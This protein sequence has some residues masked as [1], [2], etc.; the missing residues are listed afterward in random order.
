MR[1]TLRPAVIAVLAF[2]LLGFVPLFTSVEKVNAQTPYYDLFRDATAASRSNGDDA[3][4]AFKVI[5]VGS[6]ESGL[7]AVASGGDITFTE[8][9]AGS[10]AA[11]DDFECPVSGALGGVIDVSNAACDTIGEVMNIVNVPGSGFRIIPVDSLLSDSSNDTLV[12][13]SA[14]S[15]NVAGG[16]SIN[17]DTSTAFIA[18]IALTPTPSSISGFYDPVSKALVANPYRGQLPVLFKANGTSTYGSGTSTWQVL[19]VAPNYKVGTSTETVTTLY[20]QPAGATTVNN[21]LA[22]PDLGLIGRRDEKLI[23]RIANSAAAASTTI[24]ANA[25]VLPSR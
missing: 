23:L 10:E 19:S 4:I 1:T 12:E 6:E 11:V 18:S 16:L 5:Y 9:D 22:L 15:A 20:T 21:S 17:I 8:G 7:V 24:N 2:C 14:A 3:N 25:L 13:L